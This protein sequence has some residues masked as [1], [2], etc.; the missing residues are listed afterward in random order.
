MVSY[1]RYICLLFYDE[2]VGK[3]FHFL[4]GDLV[5]SRQGISSTCHLKA[6]AITR[7][8][9]RSFTC[10]ELLGVMNGPIVMTKISRITKGTNYFPRHIPITGCES[11]EGI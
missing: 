4:S 1:T 10:Y 9:F 5:R 8:L 11:R 3:C 2:S 6:G 7:L